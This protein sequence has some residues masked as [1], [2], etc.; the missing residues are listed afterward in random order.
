MLFKPVVAVVLINFVSSELIRGIESKTVVEFVPDCRDACGA[1]IGKNIK[2]AGDHCCKL[3]GWDGL[4]KCLVDDA[5]CWK[6][7]NF[8]H[9]DES[10]NSS[11]DNHWTTSGDWDPPTTQATN[12]NWNFPTTVATAR[13]NN[14]R[15]RLR[16]LENELRIVKKTL[17]QCQVNHNKY[18]KTM[19]KTKQIIDRLM[20]DELT[21]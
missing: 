14:L 8:T 19:Q 16:A 5:Y 11:F 20:N 1:S 6:T 17:H 18:V 12:E 7:K 10:T 21:G 13:S 3:Y 4:K 9:V 2:A 15:Q